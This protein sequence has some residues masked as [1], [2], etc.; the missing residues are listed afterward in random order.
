M[1]TQKKIRRKVIDADSVEGSGGRFW[2]LFL[3]CGHI[4]H[5][6]GYTKCP[7]TSFCDECT[8]IAND[9]VKRESK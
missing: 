7:K 6:G 9:L 3:E 4:G 2:E 5:S 8:E 1:T